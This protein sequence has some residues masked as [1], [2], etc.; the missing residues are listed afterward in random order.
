MHDLLENPLVK[1]LKK[2]L[3]NYG[4]IPESIK[5]ILAGFSES[6][7]EKSEEKYFDIFLKKFP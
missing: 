6:A 5:K 3:G 1:D 7:Q 4:K 2:S